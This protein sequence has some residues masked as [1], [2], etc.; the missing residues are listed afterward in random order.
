MGKK[1]QGGIHNCILK[2]IIFKFLYY[3]NKGNQCRQFLKQL[4]ALFSFSGEL[5]AE[6]IFL[7]LCCTFWED[8]HDGDSVFVLLVFWGKIGSS[9]IVTVG[10]WSSWYVNHGQMLEIFEGGIIFDS[11]NLSFFDILFEIIFLLN[12]C[13]IFLNS[14]S[15]VMEWSMTKLS[16]CSKISSSSSTTN[17]PQRIFITYLF[18]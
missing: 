5:D 11:S 17:L 8:C 18:D 2:N 6:L 3:F 1:Y 10:L 16:S 14:S 12:F 4:T 7:G 13:K 9:G 15:S